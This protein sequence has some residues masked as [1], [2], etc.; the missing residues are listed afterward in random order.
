MSEINKM[1]KKIAATLAIAIFILSSVAIFTPVHASTTA[2]VVSDTTTQ[3]S[4]DGINWVP[5]VAA[6]VHPSWPT[7]SG[8][9]WVWIESNTNPAAEYASVPLGGWYF[10]RT[11]VVSGT[12]I[13]GTL[14]VDADNSEAT[15]IN[16]HFLG[17]DG[18][19]NK[20]GPD[21]QEW[22][23]I[24]TYDLTPYLVSGTNTI[25]VRAL[26]FFDYGTFDSNPAGLIFKADIT[27][28]PLP[29]EQA[30]ATGLSNT[31]GPPFGQFV[32]DASVPIGSKLVLNIVQKV[33]NDED[34]GYNGYW[35]IDNYNRHVQVW[36][37]PSENCYYVIARY[38]G[39]WIDVINAPSPG[40][41]T[42]EKTAVTGTYEGGYIG[43]FSAT[44][45]ATPSLPFFGN[46][47]TFDYHGTTSDVLA[48]T[49]LITPFNYRTTYFTAPTDLYY[50]NWGWTYHYR[51]QT[52]NDFANVP[53]AS[54]GDIVV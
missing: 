39:K 52:W 34:S 9:T 48:Q 6:W 53:Q 41:G 3:W 20:D 35:A 17:Q 36:Q 42:L 46:I 26:N 29:P 21:N 18:S 16:G 30:C 28:T 49:H 37:M 33:I 7:I 25:L 27:F 23:T 13:S 1:N 43:T 50:I 19:M 2:T 10:Q 14:Q 45:L 40:I 51:S 44:G 32:N 15:W 11:F 24:E 54:S 5:T 4:S 22:S 12:S 47:G 8:A 38:D 31:Q